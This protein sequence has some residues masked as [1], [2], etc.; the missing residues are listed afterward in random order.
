MRVRYLDFNIY[1]LQ[2]I[3]NIYL[4]SDHAV[5]LFE[6]ELYRSTK[7]LADDCYM[8]ISPKAGFIF[9]YFPLRRSELGSPFGLLSLAPPVTNA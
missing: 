8:R 5:E 2:I 9:G 6:I 7:I 4:L 3:F 1:Y